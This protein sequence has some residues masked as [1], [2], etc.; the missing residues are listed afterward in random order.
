MFSKEFLQ[1]LDSADKAASKKNVE[2]KNET[3]VK[4]MTYLIY[5]YGFSS[6]RA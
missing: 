5:K 1:Y 2:K 3:V 6:K 4:P